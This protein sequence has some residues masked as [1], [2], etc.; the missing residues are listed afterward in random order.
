ML[1]AL[2]SKRIRIFG[3][4][5]LMVLVAIAAVA[6]YLARQPEEVKTVQAARSM[7]GT[8]RFQTE[9]YLMALR[10]VGYETQPPRELS[11]PEFYKAVALGEVD[12][13][14]SGVFDRDISYFIQAKNAATR[15]GYIA[16]GKA[17]QGY[18]IDR[19]TADAHG[20]GSQ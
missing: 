3:V 13:W 7:S 4:L 8:D 14:A 12:F 18:M 2:A 19:R 20:I 16:E 10:A 17:L 5:S 9:V 11:A 6:V 1:Q 15:I